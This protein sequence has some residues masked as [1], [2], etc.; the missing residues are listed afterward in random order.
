M[1]L[2][3]CVSKEWQNW[4]HSIILIIAKLIYVGTD[5]KNI[6]LALLQMDTCN[7]EPFLLCPE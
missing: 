1:T 5:L 7:V 4:N 6:P 3:D 2:V